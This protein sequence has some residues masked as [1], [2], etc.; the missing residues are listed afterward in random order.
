MKPDEKPKDTE[1]SVMELNTRTFLKAVLNETQVGSHIR[2][3]LSVDFLFYE[4]II[5]FFYLQHV[6]VLYH[7]PYCSFCHSVSH[8]FLTVAYLLRGLPRIVMARVDGEN[9]DL[10]WQYTVHSYPSVL[11]F[12]AHG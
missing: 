12:P 7:S 4:G 11:I 8:V 3:L 9:N 2:T 10:P 1:V 6:V 5:L